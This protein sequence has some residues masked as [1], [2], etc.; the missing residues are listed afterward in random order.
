MVDVIFTHKAIFYLVL[1]ATLL[2]ICAY[3]EWP[4]NL[5]WN[6]KR[7][8]K[9]AC[10]SD[11]YRTDPLPDDTMADLIERLWNYTNKDSEKV[12]WRRSII[13]AVIA[14]LVL[15]FILQQRVPEPIELIVSVVILYILFYQMNSYYT[16]HF[17]FRSDVFAR[18]TINKLKENLGMREPTSA[19]DFWKI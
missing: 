14:T 16:M 13:Y 19:K 7:R 15:F 17:D 1:I 10:H 4:A 11:V 9:H 5:C 3:Q 2:W 18:N 8:G 6:E 12:F